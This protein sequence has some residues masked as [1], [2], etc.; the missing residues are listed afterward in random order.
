MP[1]HKYATHCI[2]GSLGSVDGG[3]VGAM[4]EPKGAL[5]AVVRGLRASG[6]DAH[7][8]GDDIVATPKTQ[9]CDGEYKKEG[10]SLEELDVP[11]VR[12]VV[13]VGTD[14]RTIFAKT[15]AS[16]DRWWLETTAANPLSVPAPPGSRIPLR[17]RAVCDRGFA[18]LVTGEFVV[19]TRTHSMGA[20]GILIVPQSVENTFVYLHIAEVDGIATLV[21]AEASIEI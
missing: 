11:G 21:A 9:W 16:K 15:V 14:E 1:T 20:P 17:I 10:I 4:D 18:D 6:M 13:T 7:M 5:G 8:D 12:I 3:L 19:P 2:I